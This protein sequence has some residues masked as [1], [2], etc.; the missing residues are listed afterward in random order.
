MLL[1]AIVA[2]GVLFWVAFFYFGW[3]GISR[4]TDQAKE[5]DIW[6]E[7]AVAPRSDR[8]VESLLASNPKSEALLRQYVGNAIDRQDWPE[9]L[10]RAEMFVARRPRSAG[11]RLARIYVLRMSGC[12][13]KS[14][15][16]LRK[17]VRW[18][19][20]N[21]EVLLAWSE[22]AVR[23]QDW[24]EALRRLER[25]RKRA[26]DWAAGYLLAADALVASGRR[27][28]AEALLA[29]AMQ[30]IPKDQWISQA[31]ARIAEGANDLGK[32]IR[33]WEEMRALFPGEPTGFLGGAEALARAGETEAAAA[34]IRQGRDFFP[35]N[36]AIKEAAARLA[37][38]LQPLPAATNEYRYQN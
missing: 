28:E 11:G 26:P 5:D 21:R 23:R 38:E 10:R 8:H 33:L 1:L 30:R 14:L 34:L 13:A 35:G 15:A 27:D 20:R 7:L 18:M 4:R 31:A 24:P 17:A 29:E 37:A 12:E 32:A 19:P 9:A 36:A 25:L 6:F 2:A 16:L 3:K 22:E